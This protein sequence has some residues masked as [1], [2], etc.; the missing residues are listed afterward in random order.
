MA[1]VTFG[2]M[3]DHFDSDLAEVLS[4]ALSRL[5][6][7]V[8][9]RYRGPAPR[10]LGNNTL[11]L[12]WLPQNDLL[13]D[14]RT[15]LFLTHGGAGGVQEALYHGVPLVGVPLFR[16]QFTN[17]AR[18]EYLGAGR[19]VSLGGLTADKLYRTLREVSGNQ[20]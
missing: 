3:I 20:T 17:M 9:W 11:L 12:P 8:V 7:K 15:R 16:D 14:P 18:V 1:V 13:G 6:F 5:P 19:I 2:S 4:T 10:N